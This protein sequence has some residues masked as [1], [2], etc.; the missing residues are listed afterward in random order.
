MSTERTSY[1]PRLDRSFYEADAVVLW[2]L[3][4]HNRRTGWLNREFH[5]RFRETVLHCAAR[6]GLITPVYVLMPDHLHLVWAGLRTDTDQINAMAFLRTHLRPALGGARFQVQAHDHV[7]KEKERLR[8]GFAHCCQYLLLNPVRAGL[9]STAGD[10]EFSGCVVP[11]YPRLHPCDDDY[12]QK[13]WKIFE[14][15]RSADCAR[16]VRPTIQTA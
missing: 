16:H 15:M 5:L 2:T 9:A 13:F 7:L 14:Q 12:W 1:L 10:W 6:E 3:P 11:G 4:I 8:N